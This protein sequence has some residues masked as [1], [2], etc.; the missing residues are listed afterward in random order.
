M[1]G[2]ADYAEASETVCAGASYCTF[3]SQQYPKGMVG[4]TP[5]NFLFG[6]R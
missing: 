4:Q 3:P 5:D 2:L 6:P 1:G